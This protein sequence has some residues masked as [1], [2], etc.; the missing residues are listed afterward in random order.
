[1]KYWLI[2]SEPK[3]YSI[4][5]M[6]KEKICIWDGVRNYQ[7]RNF[8]QQM[9]HGDLAFFYHSNAI[10]P[11]IIGLVKILETGIADPTQF[12]PESKYYDPK[13]TPNTPR[14][15]TVSVEF[16]EEFHNLIS[17]ADLKQ[18]FTG[19]ELLVVRKGNRLSV[20]PISEIVA[21]KI[22]DMKNN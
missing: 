7:S 11:G 21:E 4:S 10:P 9:N 19:D 5:D 2:K 18:Q 6:K 8:L 20:I 16:V 15:Q 22:L 14:W 17:L 12:D 3:T 1:M 13:S